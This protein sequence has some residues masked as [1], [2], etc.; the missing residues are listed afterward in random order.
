MNNK[1][2]KEEKKLINNYS[3]SDNKNLNEY[4]NKNLI[5]EEKLPDYLIISYNHENNY[6]KKIFKKS[7]KINYNKINYNKINYNKS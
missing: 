7:N 4:Y 3:L 1:N 5:E 6:D 2:L